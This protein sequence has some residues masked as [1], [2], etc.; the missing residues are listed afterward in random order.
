MNSVDAFLALENIKST[1]FT[2]GLDGDLAKDLTN[3]I[4]NRIEKHLVRK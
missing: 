4:K 3:E 2:I 1:N